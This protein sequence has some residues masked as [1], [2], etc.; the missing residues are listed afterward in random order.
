MVKRF[1]EQTI[2][3]FSVLKWVALATVVGA[4]VGLST[5]LFLKTLSWATALTHRYP[6]YYFLLPLAFFLS[7]LTIRYLAPD[8]EGHGTE[9]V[10]EAVHKRSGRIKAIVVPV[11]LVATVMTIA[12]GG[13]AGKEGP[14]AQIGAGLSSL[15]S[16]LVKFEDADRKKLVICGISLWKKQPLGS[17]PGA[18]L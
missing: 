5:T 3:F 4:T 7:A 1:A 9:K 11:K 15:F 17:S 16:D 6:H 10:I 13:S 12:A 18:K 8:A 14:A 2:L